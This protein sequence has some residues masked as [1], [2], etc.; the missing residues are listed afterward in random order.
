MLFFPELKPV[1]NALECVKDR[2]VA[3][4]VL[5]SEVLLQV[6]VLQAMSILVEGHYLDAL[7][8]DSHLDIDPVTK[9]H[10]NGTSVELIEVALGVDVDA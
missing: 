10:R 4:D 2:H 5:L 8:R 1:G 9:W 3:F 7:V 6:Q